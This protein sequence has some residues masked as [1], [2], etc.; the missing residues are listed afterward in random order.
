MNFKR[1]AEHPLFR[2]ILDMAGVWF[3][4]KDEVCFHDP[5]AVVSIFN[6]SVCKFVRGN[7]S[8]ELGKK[9]LMGYTLF[10]E[11]LNGKH[12]IAAALI[13]KHFLMNIFQCFNNGNICKMNFL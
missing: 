13:Q 8:V 10:E 6:D 9:S 2:P 3:R 4:T 5:L 12:E 7:V 1:C 11:N